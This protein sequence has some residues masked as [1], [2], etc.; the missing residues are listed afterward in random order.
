MGIVGCFPFSFFLFFPLAYQT[1]FWG[2]GFRVD[3]FYGNIGRWGERVELRGMN[4]GR[5]CN[6]VSVC[7]RARRG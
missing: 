2:S 5:R 1:N 4:H 7:L 6:F 3:P